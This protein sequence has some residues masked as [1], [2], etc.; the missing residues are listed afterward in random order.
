MAGPIVGDDGGR[1]DAKDVSVKSGSFVIPSDV[2]SGLPGAGGNTLAGMRILEQQFGKPDPRAMAS[3]GPA[4]DVPIRISSGEFVVSPDQVAKIGGGDMQ[5]GHMIL[6][7][8]VVKLRKQH[9]AALGRL[10][11]P[12]KS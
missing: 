6:D 11:P 9:A 4:T 10:P 5:R 7:K 2:V 12:A 3:G 1:D 8:M